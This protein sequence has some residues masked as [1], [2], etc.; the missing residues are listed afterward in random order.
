MAV[1]RSVM[2]SN[3][4][5]PSGQQVTPLTSTMFE[6]QGLCLTA[7]QAVPQQSEHLWQIRRGLVRTLTWNEDGD[8][9]TLGLWGA[10][11]CI[12]RR[13]S[14][15]TPF[16]MECLS[17]VEMKALPITGQVL[18]MAMRSHLR[19][20]EELFSVISYKR[21]PQRLLRFL[22]WLGN[23]FGRQVDQGRIIDLGLTH[24]M[25]AE[26]TGITRVTATR[27]LNE[28]EREGQLLR[29]PKQRILL[30]FGTSQPER[31]AS[32]ARHRAKGIH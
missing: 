10:G 18:G 1:S 19:Y 8:L 32:M 26:I 3:R 13:L 7:G 30:Q 15:I 25:L 16:Q 31:V 27:L 5:Q 11:D 29:L 2:A 21:A 14:E 4:P 12:G 22:D 23:R 24:Q 28:F 6:S 20:M 9:V 17:P